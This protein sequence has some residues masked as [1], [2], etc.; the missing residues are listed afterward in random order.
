M[1]ILEVDMA[2]QSR[3]YILASNHLCYDVNPTLW[4]TFCALTG[5]P[6][7]QPN[8]IW[9]EQDVVVAMLAR[10]LKRHDAREN[11]SHNE[12]SRFDQSGHSFDIRRDISTGNVMAVRETSSSNDAVLFVIGS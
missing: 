7:G 9:T 3:P 1:D 12:Q 6:I 10:G 8:Y 4:H 5:R 11:D 2:D